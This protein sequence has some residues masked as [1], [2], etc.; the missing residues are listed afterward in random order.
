[1]GGRKVV[2]VGGVR[3]DRV[4]KE[5][6]PARPDASL[7]LV[8]SGGS[9][10]AAGAPP[11]A[12]V[13]IPAGVAH[14][15]A[16][17]GSFTGVELGEKGE[18]WLV[19]GTTFPALPGES[20]SLVAASSLEPLRAGERRLIRILAAAAA[21][22]LGAA[23]LGGILLG[24]RIARPL[25]DLTGVAGR[26]AAGDLELD[27][28]PRSKDEIGALTTAFA[29]MAA[30][31]RAGRAELARSE[32]LA[33]WRDAARR[34]AHEVK[35]PLTPIRMAVENL[36]RA[37]DIA[38][39]RFEALLENECGAIL[40]EVD[41][42]R[43]LVDEFSLFARL[44]EPA[45]RSVDPVAIVRHV[46][47]LFRPGLDGVALDLDL[48]QAPPRADLDPDLVGQVLKNLVGNA[49]D[50]VPRPGGRITLAC[51]AQ[52]AS[53]V[54]SVGDNGSGIPAEVRAR[55]F[56][57]QSSAKPSG[58]GLGLA[59]CRQIVERLGGQIEAAEREP[60]TMFTVTL[61]IH[62]APAPLRWRD[63]R[64]TWRAS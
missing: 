17:N 46:E 39:E 59:I 3:L 27:L 16:V 33:A 23:A 63:D 64:H 61:P 47:E 10:L 22:A 13:S 60:G 24:R 19:S 42:L 35:N 20:I 26:I 29:S 58:T 55:L 36:K 37:H 38:P 44:P 25:R 2:V 8:D 18:S 7:A 48:T 31:L 56:E 51:Q 40:E 4:V 50:A 45:V 62:S 30:A 28:A 53:I 43:R 5:R 6:P 34:M 21:A 14:E 11:F 57:P 54:F 9:I 32:R 12:L 49:L 15:L 52:N 1:M 41:A